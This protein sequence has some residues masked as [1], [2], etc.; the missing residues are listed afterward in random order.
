AMV[1]GGADGNA[2]IRHLR[3][4]DHAPDLYG[5]VI[6]ASR[7]VL[8]SDSAAVAGLVK[9]VNRGVADVARDPSAGIDAVMRRAPY[10]DRKAET[11]RLATT[12]GIEM[13]HA[14]G[15]RLGIGAVDEARLQRSIGQMAKAANLSGAPV[16]QDVFNPD[17]LPPAERRVRSLAR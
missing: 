9:A 3:F 13:A 16:A 2:R 15:R 14:E 17:F 6:M 10:A 11:L 5:S 1:Q 4:A 8:A 7:R 12:L